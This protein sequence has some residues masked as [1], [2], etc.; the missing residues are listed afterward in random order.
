LRADANARLTREAALGRWLHEGTYMCNALVRGALFALALSPVVANADPITL[1]LAFFSSDRST[2]YLAAVRPFVDAVN[3]EGKELVEIVLYSGGVLGRDIARQPQVVLDGE[4]DI[5]FVVPGYSPERF[6]DNSVVELPGLFHDTRE[7]TE[8]YTRLIAQG[9]LK[10][11]EDFFVIGAYITEPATIHSRMPIN[12]IDDLKGQR[13]RV[14]NLG[15]AAALETLG[16][17]PVQME[18]I[19][20]AAAISSGIIDGAAVAKTPLNDYGIKRVATNHYLL[21]TSGSPLALVMNRRAFE[22]LPK[23]VA[24]LIRKHS[25]EWTAARFIESYD[26]SDQLALE[27]LVSDPKRNVVLPAPSDLDR[28]QISFRSTIANW[29]GENPRHHE[30]LQKTENELTNLRTT[31]GT[32]Q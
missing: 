17:L 1:K 9:S 10:G 32:S 29:L 13:L 27:Q 31:P 20:I 11:Y 7:G 6:S 15:E 12:S 24:D 23:P 3:A 26:S 19:R 18:I 21:S 14:N 22:A 25:G 4:A 30:L 8:V 5:A 16:V 28:A 2:T